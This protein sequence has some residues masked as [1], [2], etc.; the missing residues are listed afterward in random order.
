[1]TNSFNYLTA[2]DNDAVFDSNYKRQS[3][4]L[5]QIQESGLKDLN[6]AL[7]NQQT[8]NTKLLEGIKSFSTGVNELLVQRHEKAKKDALAKAQ[9]AVRRGYYDESQTE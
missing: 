5:D 9:M 4:E 7:K 1:M 8:D 2:P 6:A 3:Q